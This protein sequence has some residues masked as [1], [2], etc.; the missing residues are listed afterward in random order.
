MSGADMS[1]L[2]MELL[3]A[4]LPS[5]PEQSKW[6]SPAEKDGACVTMILESQSPSKGQSNGQNLKLEIQVQS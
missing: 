4:G 3:K 6:L 1:S 2:L 5:L